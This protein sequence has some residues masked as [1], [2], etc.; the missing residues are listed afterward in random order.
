[1]NNPI[2]TNSEKLKTPK[3]ESCGQ[4]NCM[5]HHIS[6]DIHYICEQCLI[7]IAKQEVSRNPDKYKSESKKRLYG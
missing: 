3:C 7:E 2:P 6:D 4:F 1:M 5:L